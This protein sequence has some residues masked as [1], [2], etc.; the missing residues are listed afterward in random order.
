M[1][2]FD[3][4]QM[5]LA[6]E[7]DTEISFGNEYRI[8]SLVEAQSLIRLYHKLSEE[9]KQRM[10]NQ[11]DNLEMFDKFTDYALKQ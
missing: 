5:V 4:L 10:V 11:L 6:N 2:A 3:S 7:E 1:S 9:N 8:V